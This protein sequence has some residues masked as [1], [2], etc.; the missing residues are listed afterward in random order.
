VVGEL[1]FFPGEFVPVIDLG[2]YGRFVV[3]GE[4][5]GVI[6]AVFDMSAPAPIAVLKGGEGAA[7]PINDRRQPVGESKK[8]DPLKITVHEGMVYYCGQFMGGMAEMTVN[9]I[10]KKHMPISFMPPYAVDALHAKIR[11]MGMTVG[12]DGKMRLGEKDAAP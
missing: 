10:N 9:V 6:D 5:K 3:E 1:R 2:S 11:R 8:I 12:L 7:Q 4:K